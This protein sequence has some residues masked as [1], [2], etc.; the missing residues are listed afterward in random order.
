[1]QWSILIVLSTV[2]GAFVINT[3]G[4]ENDL[5]LED[6]ITQKVDGRIVNGTKAQLAQFPHMVSLRR[7]YTSSHFC[8]ASI[9]SE[10]WILTAAHCMYRNDELLSPA[11]FYVFTGGVKLDDKEVSPRQVRYIKDLYV[12]PD[13]DDSY[14]VND[15]A[16]LLVMTLLSL[17]AKIIS[18][19]EIYKFFVQIFMNGRDVSNDLMYLKMPLLSPPICKKLLRKITKMTNGQICAGYL[20][21][22]RDACQGD[23]GGPLMCNGSLTGIVS[24][25]SGCARPELPGFYS[26]VAYYKNWI[27]RVQSAADSCC[28]CACQRNVSNS[29]VTVTYGTLLLLI[30][31]IYL[32]IY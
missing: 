1:M 17:T 8:G 28:K 25:G 29:S 5:S 12:H 14:L 23:S 11:S 30:I 20:E 2:L 18:I 21:G 27:E 10:K 32:S 7:R 22:Q 3:E 15:V 9:I 19:N 31:G 6:T 13:F 16:L 4:T 26:E 24:G